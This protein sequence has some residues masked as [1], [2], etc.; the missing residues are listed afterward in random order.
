MIYEYL[1]YCWWTK[2]C[3]T[4][5]DDYPI[6]YKVLTN[7]NWL[8]GFLIHQQYHYNFYNSTRDS[9]LVVRLLEGVVEQLLLEVCGPRT[10]EAS[11]NISL[12]DSLENL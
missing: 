2:S 6:I 11:G 8:T 10:M 12:I 1:T 7:L 4:K 3:T 5:D 9:S